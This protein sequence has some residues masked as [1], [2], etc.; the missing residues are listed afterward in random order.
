MWA[1]SSEDRCG[2]RGPQWEWQD[3]PVAATQVCSPEDGQLHQVIHHEPKGHAQDTGNVTSWFM[4]HCVLCPCIYSAMMTQRVC[5]FI[6]TDVPC[7]CPFLLTSTP[8]EM[9]MAYKSMFA[10]DIEACIQVHSYAFVPLSPVHERELSCKLLPST[11]LFRLVQCVWSWHNNV[12]TY[13]VH[14][15]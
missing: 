3:Y 10:S 6:T 11:R 2:H 1:A 13:V 9:P 14:V 12:H 8:T 5:N 4:H 15:A 7:S